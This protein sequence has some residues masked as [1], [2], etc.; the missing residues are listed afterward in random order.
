MFRKVYLSITSVLKF[1]TEEESTET[2]RIEGL[3]EQIKELRTGTE[4]KPP[5]LMKA[6]KRCTSLA[7]IKKRMKQI[8]ASNA[9]LR[10]LLDLFSS[11]PAKLAQVAAFFET[12]HEMY[13]DVGLA[14]TLL[15]D[16]DNRSELISA[17]AIQC[18]EVQLDERGVLSQEIMDRL[19]KLEEAAA[20]EGWDDWEEVEEIRTLILERCQELTEQWLEQHDIDLE[21]LTEELTAA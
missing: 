12:L 21:A 3:V 8:M 6:S 17:I 11:T 2:W 9:K 7:R 15:E 20:E 4:E 1:K 16:A 13:A 19:K 10:T 14:K 5:N 18:R